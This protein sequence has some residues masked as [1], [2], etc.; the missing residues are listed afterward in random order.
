MLLKSFIQKNIKSKFFLI[1][2]GSSADKTINFIKN[3]NYLSFFINCCIYTANLKKY[4]SI[5]EKYSDFIKDICIDCG[6]II[7]YINTTFQKLNEKSEQILINNI[8]NWNSYKNEY[9]A[10][11]KELSNFYGDESEN[12]FS[13]NFSVI[14]DAIKNE[15]F[16]NIIKESLL[17]CFQT[18]SELNKKNYEK[19]IICYF[20][21]PKKKK[22]INI[23]LLK[24]K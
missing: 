21:F 7:N 15:D 3:N 4:S 9:I 8:I 20:T 14:N 11:H 1:V 13:L 18:F 22:I 2:N 19:I 24:F 23:P 16:P 5:K 12:S 17:K 6:S 10:L